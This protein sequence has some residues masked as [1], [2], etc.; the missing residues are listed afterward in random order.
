VQLKQPKN[1]G[2]LA[3]H[4][5]PLERRAQERLGGAKDGSGGAEGGGDGKER[6]GAAGG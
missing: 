5:A 3:Q 2:L 4:V 6:G 1:D